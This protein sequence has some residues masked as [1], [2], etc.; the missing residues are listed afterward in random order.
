MLDVVIPTLNE[1]LFLPSL[2]RSLQ[3]QTYK[4]F[5][6]FVSDGGSTDK[7]VSIAKQFAKPMPLTVVEC[8]KRG[9]SRRRNM[10]A[11]KGSASAIIFL[12][13]DVIVRP[14]FLQTLIKKTQGID[15]ANCWAHSQSRHALDEL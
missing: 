14:H 5:H 12:D 4:Q 7:T 8:D 6:V 11:K 15:L 13:A 9:V 10:G 2:L 3:K 1:E